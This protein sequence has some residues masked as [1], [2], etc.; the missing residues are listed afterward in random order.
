VA[1]GVGS[2]AG[3]VLAGTRIAE[4][5]GDA[6]PI[7]KSRLRVLHVYKEY[8]PWIGGIQSV[9]QSVAEGL[10][11]TDR[12]EATVLACGPFGGSELDRING[13]SV[14]RSASFGSLLSQPFSLDFLRRF[15]KFAERCDLLILHHPFPLGFAAHWL[16]GCERKFVV[17]YHSD[18]V[19]QR[20]TAR[21]LRPLLT[22]TLQKSAAIFVSSR[23]SV[24]NSNLL[25]E[26]ALKCIEVPYGI[27]PARFDRTTEVRSEADRIRTQYGDQLVLSV[28][29]LVYYKGFEYLIRAMK[30]VPGKLLIIGDGPLKATLAERIRREGL[31]DRVFLRGAVSDLAPY[32]HACDLFVLP[33]IAPSEAFGLVQLEAMAS[34]KPVINTD[35]PTAVPEVSVHGVTGLTV[36]PK[37]SEALAAAM[38]QLLSDPDRRSYLG[39]NA[40]RRVAENFTRE[41]FLKKVERELSA[42]W[43]R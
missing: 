37:D 11:Y 7:F 42:V 26:T 12:F 35:L 5:S 32:Y 22:R 14:Y 16:A 29:R 19:R 24:A 3:G 15:R 27:D 20:V 1:T 33:S 21:L 41:I 38:R 40:I 31:S 10:N 17:W 18:I 4:R 30:C 34:G 2:S 28:G 9:I 43:E 8:A 6:R 25:S 13:I 36:P 23:R 39:T